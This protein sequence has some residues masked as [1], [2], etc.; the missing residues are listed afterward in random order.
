MVFQEN[1]YAYTNLVDLVL[2]NTRNTAYNHPIYIESTTNDT[3]LYG[4]FKTLVRRATAGL[5]KIGIKQGDCIC[6]SSPNNVSN[7]LCISSNEEK[8]T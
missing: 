8:L 7:Y 3:I 4:E 6:I 1:S 5:R 2:S